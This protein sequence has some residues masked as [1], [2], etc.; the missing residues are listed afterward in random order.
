MTTPTVLVT[1]ATGGIGSQLIPALRAR[2][3]RVRAMVRRPEQAAQV[4][5]DGVEPVVADLQ[6][7]QGIAAALDGVDAAFLN[8]PSAPDA[9]QVQI[10]FADLAHRAGLPRLVLL[11]QYAARID[12]PVRF[13]RWH[14]E[15]EAHVAGLG[16]AHTVLRPNLFMQGLLAMAGSVGADGRFGAPIGDAAVSVV[17]T[18]DIADVA[19]VVLTEPGHDAATYTLTGPQARTHH[20]IAAA[21]STALGREI[22]FTDVPAPQFASA[23]RGLLPDW[24]LDGLVED[25]A[26]YAAGEAAAVDPAIETITGRPARDLASFARDHTPASA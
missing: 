19:A 8:S 13:L 2:G 18:R 17:D 12:S 5:A 22:T 9:A 23:L 20:E 10:R 25:Y 11:S 7:P 6:D 1:G 15:V 14:A 24:Q 4:A 3:A 16:I 26:H 21:L